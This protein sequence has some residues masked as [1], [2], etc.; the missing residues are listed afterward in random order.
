MSGG[1]WG[2]GR[3]ARRKFKKKNNHKIKRQLPTTHMFLTWFWQ[4]FWLQ[5]KVLQSDVGSNIRFYSSAGTKSTVM[6][7][8]L[9]ARNFVFYS[10]TGTTYYPHPRPDY[11]HVYDYI[12]YGYDCCY[13]GKL[14]TFQNLIPGA[15]SLRC[16]AMI[17][18]LL[19]MFFDMFGTSLVLFFVDVCNWLV[20][21]ESLEKHD[22]H[23]PH[24]GTCQTT[25]RKNL[26]HTYLQNN[27]FLL[28]V[29]VA[30][31]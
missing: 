20:V 3:K 10:S 30:S 16:L 4:G 14:I 9:R 11:C 28:F 13:D 31:F 24:P 17:W 27:M 8:S 18:K 22:K 1:T 5:D 21:V 15:I 25:Y 29:R 23:P 6:Q 19:G 12:Y 26:G 2:G 7:F